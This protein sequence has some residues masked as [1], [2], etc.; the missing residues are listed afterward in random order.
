MIHGAV[1]DSTRL[2]ELDLGV[3]ARGTDPHKSGRAGA[4][5]RDVPVSFGGIAITPVDVLHSD[6]GIVVVA[7]S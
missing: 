6:D 4:G 1:R 3:K 7:A 5:E 2:R